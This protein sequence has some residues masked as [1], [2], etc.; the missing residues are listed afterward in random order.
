MA[1]E[2]N[3][4]V[5]EADGKKELLDPDGSDDEV[6]STEAV[7]RMTHAVK[8]VIMATAFVRAR[9]C[10]AV[11]WQGGE[12]EFA[13]DLRAGGHPR[14]L[15]TQPAHAVLLLDTGWLFH[16]PAGSVLARTRPAAH[17]CQGPC[18]WGHLLQVSGVRDTA[19][20]SATHAA[21]KSASPS[22]SS[23]DHWAPV[24]CPTATAVANPSSFA[25]WATRSS[26]YTLRL[27]PT[28]ISAS[29]AGFSVMWLLNSS[30]FC[31]L[32]IARGCAGL[33]AGT[34]GVCSAYVSD[35]TTRAERPRELAH[36]QGAV[37]VGFI[38]GPGIG[39]AIGLSFG[40]PN[41]HMAWIVTCLF[42]ASI[43]FGAFVT[44][45]FVL[46]DLP[47]SE[48]PVSSSNSRS[49]AAI[50]WALLKK[51]DIVL[52][53]VAAFV[54]SFMGSLAH[55]FFLRAQLSGIQAPCSR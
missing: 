51:R 13:H 34:Q 42:A 23:W 24:C 27:R 55:F 33:F 53:I 54:A 48:M 43:A 44:G 28:S 3:D 20:A 46:R 16:R 8:L 40:L 1:S 38:A 37:T 35:L 49:A 2:M 32:F 50:V 17:F 9:E 5:L 39:I 7:S 10:S 26:W 4:L 6:E 41:I 45:L 11:V 12:R 52:V 30:F 31:R 21:G 29:A 22:A 47:S 14:L 19:N 25:S 36:L 18:V 15:D